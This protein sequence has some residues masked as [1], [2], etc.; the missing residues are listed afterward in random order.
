M[1]HT[2]SEGNH[3]PPLLVKSSSPLPSRVLQTRNLHA[4]SHCLF[5]PVLSRLKTKAQKV[6]FLAGQTSRLSVGKMQ[7]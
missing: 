6:D 4:L 7:R 3:S 2:S 5:V 1:Q